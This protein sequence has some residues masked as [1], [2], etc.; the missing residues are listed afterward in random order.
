[1]WTKQH[2]YANLSQNKQSVTIVT[3]TKG[4]AHSKMDANAELYDKDKMQAMATRMMSN[5][6]ARDMT[7]ST[8]VSKVAEGEINLITAQQPEGDVLN[9]VQDVVWVQV[10]CAVDSG[11]CANVAP[12]NIFA[13]T[14]PDA[15]K[16]EPKYCAA[17]GSPI[18]HLG[19]L[20]AEGM[21]DEG[22]ALKIDIDIGKVTRPL[23]SVFKMTSAGHKVR[24]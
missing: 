24:F 15:P 12:T 13:I 16:L 4:G 3:Q 8:T 1:M 17:D 7:V 11:A 6:V 19:P 2:N 14:A 10:P 20:V 21:S 23:I 9:V 22:T 18:A 5:L